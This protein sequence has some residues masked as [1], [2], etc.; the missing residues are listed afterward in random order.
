MRVLAPWLVA[1]AAFVA[2]VAGIG[3]WPV[4]VFQDD[5]VYAVLAKALA[6]GE[7]YRF[8]QMPGAPNATHYPPGY[9][10]LLAGLWKLYPSFPENVTLFKFANAVLLGIAAWFA[11]RFAVK[12]ARLSPMVAVVAVGLFTAC[13]PVVLLSVMVLS[14]PLFLAVLFPTLLAAERA[15]DSGRMRDAAVAGLAGTLLAMIRTL[16]FLVVPATALALAWRR[17]WR[18]AVTVLAVGAAV[19]LPWQIWVAAHSHE[20]PLVFLGKYGSYSG[21]LA[22]AI[23][24]EGLPWVI[25]VAWF[26][27]GRLAFETWTHTG[28]VLAPLAVRGLATVAVSGLLL[29]GM[30]VALPR[31]RAT[32]LFVALYLGIVIAWPFAPARFLWGIWPL[33][34]ML[35]ALGAHAVI[36]FGARPARGVPP[37]SLVRRLVPAGYVGSVVAGYLWFNYQSLAQG[38]SA[39]VQGSV[40]LRAK[41]IAE[42]VNANTAPDAVL[43][44]DDD[45]LIYLYTG[46]RTIPNSAFTAQEHMVRQSPAFAVATLRTILGTYDVD[47]VLAGSDYGSWAVRGLSSASPPELRIVAQVGAGAVFAPVA[48]GGR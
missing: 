31:V 46:R 22:D 32:V 2:A 33:I 15:T 48:G 25:K 35:F 27:L 4:G 37:L 42:W 9:P 40:A 41:P 28:T 29:T 18:A 21:W 10:L 8:I 14:E 16:G 39:Q 30:I 11:H 20:V 17:Q 38:W 3:P 19:M 34:G 6:S 26:N 1:V 44:T 13:S 47:Y 5:G 36:G 43:S 12:R 24:T 23:R 7:G 45:L